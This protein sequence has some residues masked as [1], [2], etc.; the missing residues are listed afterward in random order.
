MTSRGATLLEMLTAVAVLGVLMAGVGIPAYRQYAA[1]RAAR[2]A[3]LTV[4][5]D[6][7]LLSRAAQNA[8]GRQGASLVIESVDPL[9]YDGYL[10][11]P[12]WAD[13]QSTLGPLLIHRTFSGV[14]LEGPLDVHTP[15]LFAS[16]GSAQYLVAGSPVTQHGVLVL[17]FL[18]PNGGQSATIRLNLLTGNDVAVP[19]P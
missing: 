16:N 13:P 8:D 10:G 7:A 1:S 18:P 14:T 4:A 3:A 15:L 17:T 6:V 11:R 12:H 19:G 9:T 2:D 5:A